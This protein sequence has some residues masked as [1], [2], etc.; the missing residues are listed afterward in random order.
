VNNKTWK[1]R[2]E[3]RRRSVSG[4]AKAPSRNFE[5]MRKKKKRI[6]K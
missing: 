5:R 6:D 1:K 4:Q 2:K 3:R